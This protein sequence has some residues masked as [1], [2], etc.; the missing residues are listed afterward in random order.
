M[1][2]L[3]VAQFSPFN[4]RLRKCSG[5]GSSYGASIPKTKGMTVCAK[6]LLPLSSSSF[7]GSKTRATRASGILITFTVHSS[8]SPSWYY[9]IRKTRKRGFARFRPVL[10]RVPSFSFRWRVYLTR[11]FE[12]TR[13]NA[14]FA[15]VCRSFA[16]RQ[17]M[18]E[19]GAEFRIAKG[20]E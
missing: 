5:S 13:R 17:R 4:R 16:A 14:F 9:L 7:F 20:A 19:G 18:K 8:L 15:S 10:W 12:C 11:L 1:N 6:T 3:N 2:T